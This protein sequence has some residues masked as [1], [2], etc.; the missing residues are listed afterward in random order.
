MDTPGQR[1]FLVVE[2]IAAMRGL[3][4]NLLKEIGYA[5][6]EDVDSGQAGLARLRERPFDCCIVELRMPGID[7]L[8]LLRE[9]RADAALKRMPVLLVADQATREDVI[10]A[11]Q[12]GASACVVKPFTRAILEDR[13]ASILQ[14]AMAA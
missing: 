4:R 6:I 5:D 13:I 14:R 12:A 9:V 3:F 11:A 10:A 1:R 7:G 8:A 2:P